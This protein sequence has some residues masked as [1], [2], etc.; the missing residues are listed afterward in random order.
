MYA[1]RSYYDDIGVITTVKNFTNKEW[2]DEFYATLPNRDVYFNALF[3]VSG[4]GRTELDFK[5]V[6]I[7]VLEKTD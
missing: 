3:M 6:Q 1:I 7:E 4:V 5:L 2:L